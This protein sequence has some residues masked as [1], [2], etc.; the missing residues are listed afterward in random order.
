MTFLPMAKANPGAC[1]IGHT[2]GFRKE[3]LQN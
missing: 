1:T 2:V 3:K